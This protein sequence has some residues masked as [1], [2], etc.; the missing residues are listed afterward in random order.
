MP[1]G[2][3]LFTF[4]LTMV[5]LALLMATLKLP[6]KAKVFPMIAL[7][8]ALGLLSVQILIDRLGS[9]RPEAATSKKGRTL[10]RKH[11]VMGAWMAAL[12]LMLW[13]IGFMGTVVLLPFLYLR[14]HRETWLLSVGLSL[15][16]GVFFYV[17]FGLV[18][19]MPLYPGIL[20]EKIWG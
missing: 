11:L 3:T 5:A 10:G 1:R 16:C 17:L 8:T 15:G 13:I 19:S 20:G 6:F 2:K 14:L 12:L 7:L 18:V 9:G 4:F